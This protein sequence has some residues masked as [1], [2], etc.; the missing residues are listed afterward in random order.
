MEVPSKPDNKA[1]C[2][3]YYRRRPKT[4][5]ANLWH[6]ERFP[7]HTVF[8][9]VTGFYFLLPDQR[10]CFEECVYTHITDSLEIAFELLVIQNNTASETFV[11]KS[12]AMQS[13]DWRFIIGVPAWR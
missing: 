2:R 1:S 9:A 13:A 11:D 4:G 3:S 7:W 8:T 5:L 10:L 12:G 6:A